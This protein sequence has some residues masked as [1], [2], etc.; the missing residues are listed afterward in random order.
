MPKTGTTHAAYLRSA[1]LF[2]ANLNSFVCDFF[3]RQKLQTQHLTLFVLEQLPVITPAAFDKPLPRKFVKKM[4]DAKLMN[5]Y[6]DDPTVADC[7]IPQ[8][9]ALTYTA[10]DMAA[11]AKDLGFVD[12][13]GVV[14]P[15]FV[16][17]EAERRARMAALDAVFF[18]L[19]GLGTDD[20]TYIMDSFPIVCEQDTKAF[21]QYQTKV[22]VLAW[23]ALLQN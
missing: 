5:G 16:W 7:V 19:Y 23:L 12:K 21:G 6:H 22:D 11:F 14:L 13:T 1:S 20:A 15:P 10:H 9:L 17:D 3:L 18:Y 2:L 4:R 8:V